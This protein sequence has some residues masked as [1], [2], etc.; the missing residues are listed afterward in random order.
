MTELRI[1]EQLVIGA[2]APDVWHALED[3]AAHARWHAFV[4][5]ISGEHRLGHARRRS[6]LIG[7]KHGE[8]RELCV[9]EEQ[10]SR[11]HGP[12]TRTRP[13][14]AGW[15]RTGARGLFADATARRDARHPR[16]DFERNNLPEHVDF[17]RFDSLVAEGRRAPVRRAGTGARASD[18]SRDH[19][20]G[21]R[22]Y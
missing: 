18:L 10:A 21:G 14:L 2:S 7:G 6:V 20:R 11:L 15:S 4:T 9:V 22:A 19:H 8:T 16:S 3:A 17:G 12:Y 1:E 13:V 5:E